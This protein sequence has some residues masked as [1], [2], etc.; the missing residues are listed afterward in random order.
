MFLLCASSIRP[1]CCRRS[2]NAAIT[3]ARTLSET[4]TSEGLVAKFF[5]NH[6]HGKFAR[7]WL[8]EE[9]IRATSKESVYVFGFENVQ[10]KGKVDFESLKD[11]SKTGYF[12]C[13]GDGN[14]SLLDLV[15]QTCSPRTEFPNRAEGVWVVS[16]KRPLGSNKKRKRNAP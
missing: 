14:G 5:G 9:A 3:A 13:E 4:M 8:N 2:I 12:F 16:P 10:M 15:Q 11:R 1:R 6:L 7:K